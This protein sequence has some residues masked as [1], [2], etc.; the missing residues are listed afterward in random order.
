[1][2]YSLNFTVEPFLPRLEDVELKF[3]SDK[4]AE[5]IVNN[6]SF[7]T[8]SRSYIKPRCKKQS[9]RCPKPKRTMDTAFKR[10]NFNSSLVLQMENSSSSLPQRS[11]E[12]CSDHS[13]K[14]NKGDNSCNSRKEFCEKVEFDFVGKVQLK[15][16]E[17]KSFQK[18]M[19]NTDGFLWKRKWNK[20][21]RS[22]NIYYSCTAME[23]GEKCSAV[24]AFYRNFGNSE[25]IV[26]YVSAHSGAHDIVNYVEG[27]TDKPE[28]QNQAHN[29]Q[30]TD[31]QQEF[32]NEILN[33]TNLQEM[34]EGHKK[35][36]R[37]DDN[38]SKRYAVDEKEL[39][40]DVNDLFNSSDIEFPE[41]ENSSKDNDD[42][43]ED[44][45]VKKENENPS[46]PSPKKD[47]TCDKHEDMAMDESCWENDNS[48]DDSIEEYNEKDGAPE[49][50]INRDVKVHKMQLQE[51]VTM[52]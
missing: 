25:W 19:I 38:P 22:K 49:M 12:S 24:K 9:N 29:K 27:D 6:D 45:S 3:T 18:S 44:A 15:Q 17:K 34:D 26:E 5:T 43:R 51:N 40:F 1:M 7:K 30:T 46:V 16:H 41:N 33:S 2:N 42:R 8:N 37:K 14:F 48:T 11:T 28:E 35:H 20:Q 50:R 13:S 32:A 10:N 52:S 39:S 36:E 21:D 23:N 31:K 47:E 4:L